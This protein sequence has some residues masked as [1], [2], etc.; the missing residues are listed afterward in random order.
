MLKYLEIETAPN[1]NASIIWLH[2]LGADGHDFEPIVPELGLPS[3]LPVR[4]IFPHAPQ[5]PVTVNGGFMM[6][7]WYDI[8][9]D[10]IEG[11]QDAEGIQRSTTAVQAFIDQEKERGIKAEN[12]I[13][14][15]FSQGGALALYV[16]THQQ[17]ALAGILA[18]SCYTLLPDDSPTEASKTTPITQM[19]GTHD[20]VVP[21]HL[22]E[23]SRDF[24]IQSGFDV[25]YKAYPM[26]HSLCPPQITHIGQWLTDRLT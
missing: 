17:E 23:A 21:I 11:R 18:L 10:N 14:A 25:Q 2:G 1:P 8:K 20:G 6:P 5:M 7:A 4:F 3:S 13:L 12:I 9:A 15:G 24:L 26:E 16:G 19:H 22:G